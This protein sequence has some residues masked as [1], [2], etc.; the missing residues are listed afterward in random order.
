MKKFYSILKL[1]PNIATQDSVAIGILLYDGKK[2]RY[3]FS[4]RKRKLAKNLLNDKNVNLKFIVNQIIEKCDTIN[5]DK[6]ELQCFSKFDELSKISYFDYLNK[7]SNGLIQFSKPKIILED[8]NDII[9]EKLVQSLFAEP[10]FSLNS[11]SLKNDISAMRNIIY[12]KLINKIDNKVHIDYKFNPEV[13]QSIY[14]TYEMDC[15]GLNG[16]LIGAKSFSFENSLQTIDKNLSHYFTLISSLTSK[17]N[18]S[19]IENDFYLITDEPQNIASKEHKLWESVNYNKI[20]TVINPEESDII[21]KSIFD[22]NA[23]KFLS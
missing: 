21:A 12:E 17:Y 5:L 6:K 23:K 13:F 10:V 3:H 22:K 9:F 15:I 11:N 2:F 7:Y 1:S 4:E 8:I 18:K 20:I 19:L 16:S 14:F